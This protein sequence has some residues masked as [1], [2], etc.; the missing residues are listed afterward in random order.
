MWILLSLFFSCRFLLLHFLPIFLFPYT[1]SGLLFVFLKPTM[2]V[3]ELLTVSLE[4]YPIGTVCTFS[5][6]HVLLWISDQSLNFRLVFFSVYY[7]FLCLFLSS[8]CLYFFHSIPFALSVPPSLHL[9]S[10]ILL[11]LILFSTKHSSLC[12][13]RPSVSLELHCAMQTPTPSYNPYSLPK[14]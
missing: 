4:I 6:L 5:T 1:F 13:V 10:R 3:K 14:I 12:T 11:S 9:I 8:F 2:K 7:F